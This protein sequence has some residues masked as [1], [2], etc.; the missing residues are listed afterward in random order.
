MSVTGLSNSGVVTGW[1]RSGQTFS[2]QDQTTSAFTF[3]RA[4]HT[5]G[6]L[7]GKYTNSR[8]FAINDQG[9]TTGTLD[10]ALFASNGRHAF[11][12][13]GN[14][15][16]TASDDL[17]IAFGFEDIQ[18]QSINASGLVAGTIPASGAIGCP[19]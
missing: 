4:F 2:L 19:K 7:A 15:P 12:H 17:G 8:A 10:P 1:I 14:G 6:F 5:L 3:E 16:L 18:P 9:Q 13:V 11:R